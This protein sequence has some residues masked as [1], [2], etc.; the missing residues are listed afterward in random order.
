MSQMTIADVV[1]PESDPVGFEKTIHRAKSGQ[2]VR[3]DGKYRERACA[4]ARRQKRGRSGTVG[5]CGCGG[6]S[7]FSGRI[8]FVNLRERGESRCRR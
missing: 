5:K 3:R 7:E 4:D 8:A 6:R 2:A 1:T